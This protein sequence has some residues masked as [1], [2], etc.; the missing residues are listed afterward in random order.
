MTPSESDILGSG[1]GSHLRWFIGHAP[2]LLTTV[3]AATA[4]VAV[5]SAQEYLSRHGGGGPI[6]FET[7]LFAQTIGAVVWLALVPTLLLPLARRYPLQ[8]DHLGPAVAI[9]TGAGLLI[10]ALHTFIV[11]ALFASW[12]YGYSPLATRDVFRD[13]MF[14]G[15]A[16]SVLLYFALVAVISARAHRRAAPA[17]PAPGP[18]GQYLRRVLVTAEGRT[19]IL[20]V[21]QVDWFEAADNHVIVHAGRATHTVRGPLSTLASHLTPTRFSRI[22]RST[23]VNLESVQEVQHWFHGE[24]VVVLKDQTRL[25]VGRTYREA[26]LGALE[27]WR[28]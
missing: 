20:P 25:R 14:T 5:L 9:H 2:A 4:A 3:V 27:G 23:V 8:H 6:S 10:A 7:M 19:T 22:H 13:R 17:E 26:F 21:G 16:I 12:Y 24:L 11:A 15:Y 1:T 18:S 28:A